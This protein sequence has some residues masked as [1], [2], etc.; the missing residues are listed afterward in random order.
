MFK[1]FAEKDNVSS[2]AQ[3]RNTDV[4]RLKQRLIQDYPNIESILDEIL[5]KKDAPKLVKCQEHIEIIANSSGEA[6]FFRHRDGPPIPVLRMLHKYPFIL[7]PQQVDKGAIRFVLSGA[8]IMCPGL[9]SPGAK[10]T[11]QS[12]KDSICAVMAEGKE[13][14]LAIG[15]LKMSS[16]DIQQI[17]KGIG[18]ETLHYLNDGLW[19]I[20][21]VK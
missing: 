7:P 8:N 18:I 14:A 21:P 3:L 12:P 4:K 10:M 11:P 9:T 16:D 2:V 19:N 17:N 15:Q 5:P 6:L 20:K 13:H 1:K